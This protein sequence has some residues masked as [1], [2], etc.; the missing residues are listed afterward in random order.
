MDT[1]WTD[2]G[3]PFHPGEH[4]LQARVGIR[5][6]MEQF[7]RRVIRDY[8]PDQH[9][10]FYEG[11][12]YLYVGS[13]DADGRPWASMVSGNRGF[14]RTPSERSLQINALPHPGDPLADNLTG[15]QPIGL[16]GLDLSNRRRNRINGRVSAR[17]DGGFTIDVDQ[18]FGNCPKY[19]RVREVNGTRGVTAESVQVAHGTVL[20]DELARMVA[21]AETFFIA[22]TNP[23]DGA[24]GGADVS[25]RG[26]KPGFVRVQDGAVLS[27]PDFSGNGHFNTF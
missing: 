21:A 17:D 5:E 15:G 11:L 23:L 19:I 22:T 16:L 27:F 3:S 26:G 10:E 4:A 8:L 20:T 12:A 9:R 2:D 6:D 1:G 25:H 14:V 7:G 18:A 13:V 24:T